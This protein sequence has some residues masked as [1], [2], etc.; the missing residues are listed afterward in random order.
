[1]LDQSFTSQSTVSVALPA[2]ADDVRYHASFTN[3]LTLSFGCIDVAHRA[4]PDLI[5][6]KSLIASC[7][8]FQVYFSPVVTRDTSVPPDAGDK[9]EYVVSV[10]EIVLFV[11]VILLPAV[12]L[13]CLAYT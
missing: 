13:S 9:L 8:L 3:E 10:A 6:D 12:S 11:I 5:V 2:N 4:A 7:L 1:M